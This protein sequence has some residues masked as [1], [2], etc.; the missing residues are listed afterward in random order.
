[1]HPRFPYGSE[2]RRHVPFH[3]Q[4]PQRLGTDNRVRMRLLRHRDRDGL[5]GGARRRGGGL[6]AGLMAG[7]GRGEPAREPPASGRKMTRSAEEHASRQCA[8]APGRARGRRGS[9]IE[10][11]G[12]RWGCRKVMR[13]LLFTLQ[14]FIQ[15]LQCSRHRVGSQ[16]PSIR[17]PREEPKNCR[18]SKGQE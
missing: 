17:K 15:V 6:W 12:W 16:D 14:P 18:N 9:G 1:M 11:W 4:I 5:E 3:P 8:R 7:A 13:L 2:G 10:V